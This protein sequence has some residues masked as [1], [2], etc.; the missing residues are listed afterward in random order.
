MRRASGGFQLKCWTCC[1]SIFGNLT[2]NVFTIHI[3]QITSQ[4]DAANSQNGIFKKNK[5]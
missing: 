2:L 4:L 3:I 1:L 5:A